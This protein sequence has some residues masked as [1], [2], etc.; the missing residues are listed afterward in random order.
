M[1]ATD[2]PVGQ[3]VARSAPGSGATQLL[4]SR[5]TLEGRVLYLDAPHADRPLLDGDHWSARSAELPPD[6]SWDHCVVYLPK[7]KRRRDLYLAWAAARAPHLYVVGEK[8]AGIKG[9]AKALGAVGR[10]R[11]VGHGNHCQ[12]VTCTFDA[13][14]APVDLDDWCSSFEVAA[15]GSTR[16]FVSLPGVFS[17]GHLDHASQMMLTAWTASDA[18][19]DWAG[20]RVLDVG[21][22]AGVFGVTLAGL[23]ARVTCVDVDALALEATRRNAESAGLRAEVQFSDV[24]S[25][26]RGETYDHIVTN[27]PFHQGVGTEYETT[28]RIVAEAKDHLRPGGSLWVVANR[29]LPWREAMEAALGPVDVLQE[30]NRFVVWRA[31]RT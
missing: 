4:Q 25:G 27:P 1:D 19:T 26:V 10:A 12:L 14:G 29:F 6:G 8:R 15:A 31:T 13:V 5:A 20:K 30:S 7:G 24:Y 16:R 11:N 22:G 28:R 2:P 18:G 3:L 9:V 21:C 17:E 23:G